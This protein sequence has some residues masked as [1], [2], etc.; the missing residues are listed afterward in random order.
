MMFFIFSNTFFNELNELVKNS[1]KL[2]KSV[3]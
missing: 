3:N 2:L 1:K